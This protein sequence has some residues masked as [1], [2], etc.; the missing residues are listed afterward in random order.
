MGIEERFDIGDFICG[1]ISYERTVRDATALCRALVAGGK[2]RN[3]GPI[4]VYDRM[5]HRGRPQLWITDG[6]ILRFRA[7]LKD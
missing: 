6:P 2:H 7:I 5:A 4:S 3:C 1:S